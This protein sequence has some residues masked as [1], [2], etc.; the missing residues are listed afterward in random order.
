MIW[1]DIFVFVLLG[2][3]V[4]IIF[5]RWTEGRL[6]RDNAKRIQ[7][8]SSCG[9]LYKVYY[10]DMKDLDGGE[11]GPSYRI[12]EDGKSITCKV[13]GRTSY[14]ETDVKERY[15]GCCHAFHHLYPHGFPEKRSA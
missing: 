14:H 6:W 4:G 1:Q 8:H 15:C 9:R 3:M 7:R 10:A 12:A 5:G 2:F 11:L 13:C